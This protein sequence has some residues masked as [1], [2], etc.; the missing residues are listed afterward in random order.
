[1][2]LKNGTKKAANLAF[3]RKGKS[4]ERHGAATKGNLVVESGKKYK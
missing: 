2:H 4:A 3:C 1:V